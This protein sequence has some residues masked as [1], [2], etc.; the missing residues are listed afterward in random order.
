MT[1]PSPESS[2]S[3]LLYS[4]NGTGLGHVT[5]LMAIAR[6]LRTLLNG[7]DLKA[8]I[9]FLSCSDAD[10]L[11]G[12]QGFPSFKLPS[13]TGLRRAMLSDGEA[14][15]LIRGFAGAAIEAIR[16]DVLVVD[17]FP[18]GSYDELLPV[19]G[20][21]E[22]TKV[23]V[24]REQRG[25]Y[26]ASVPYEKLLHTFHLLLMPHPEGHFEL[27]FRLPRGLRA[28]WAGDIIFG[29]RH[30]QWTKAKVRK[31]LGIGRHKTVVYAAAGGGGDP[32]SAQ[33]LRTI[34]KAVLE[35]P[36]THLVVGAGPLY[37][38][39]G[40]SGPNLTWTTYYPISRLFRGFDFAI[41][42]SGYNTVSELLHFS[43]PAILYAQ[44]RGADDQMARA[45]RVAQAGAAIALERLTPA[46]LRR[47]LQKILLAERR[48]GMR[49]AARAL[50]PRNGA[51]RA[52]EL[53][54]ETALPRKFP[55]FRP[56]FQPA[57]APETSEVNDVPPA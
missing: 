7:L 40:T 10:S 4:V 41:S 14:I 44:T 53:I 49:R 43:L 24:F 13:K 22:V 6:W 16:P 29:E 9:Y 12:A 1:A 17:T 34:S 33:T 31:A 32:H 56:R 57:S 35:L 50:L 18:A 23:F 55:D 46:T 47:A 27:P 20:R 25:D 37:R 26:A 45:Q 36:K 11:I 42:S 51:R 30:E 54:L 28:A 48:A 39:P 8:Q 52:A 3:V 21:E 19:L 15:G 38:Q 2:L 5:R